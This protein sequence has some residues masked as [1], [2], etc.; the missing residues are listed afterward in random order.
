[1][2]TSSASVLLVE[3]DPNDVILMERAFRRA[4]M[5]SDFQVVRDGEQ[6]VDYLS[7]KGQSSD[8]TRTPLPALV[9]L[10]LKLPRQSGFEVLRWMRA[11]SGLRRIPVL[12]LTSSK[13]KH[14]IIRAYELGANAYLLKPATFNDLV[15]LVKTISVFWMI[16]NQ[17]SDVTAEEVHP[18]ES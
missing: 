1:M 12:I 5:M 9:L 11:Q 7:G 13:E 6:A 15:E 14:D 17:Y 10:D 3:D 8:L 2:A 4:G 16:A 18:A